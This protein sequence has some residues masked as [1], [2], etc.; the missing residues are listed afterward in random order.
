VK[1]SKGRRNSDTVR[2]RTFEEAQ[3]AVPYISSVA[4]SLREH[5]VAM[6]AKHRE[7]QLFAERPGRRDRKAL[8]EEQEA[9]RDLEKAEKDCQGALEELSELDVQPLDPVQGIA[10]VPF[11]HDGQ[12]AWYVFDLFDSQPIHS[13]RYQSD[14]NETRRE[15]TAPQMS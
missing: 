15:L 12:A 2:V 8:I 6:L 7:V 9:R 4:R 13:W 3:A 11:L 10:L 1:H 5:Y 14:P